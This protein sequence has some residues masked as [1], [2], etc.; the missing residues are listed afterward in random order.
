[1]VVGHFDLVH[2]FLVLVDV[3]VVIVEVDVVEV[4]VVDVEV[5]V[6]VV[7]VV[8]QGFLQTRQTSVS[9]DRASTYNC[10]SCVLNCNLLP[11]VT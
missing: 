2:F 10:V 8:V 1:V 3:V 6:E 7:V 4:D 5:V 9:L 11:G